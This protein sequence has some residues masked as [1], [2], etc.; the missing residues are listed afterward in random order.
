MDQK[1]W[2][3]EKPYLSYSHTIVDAAKFHFECQ[4]RNFCSGKVYLLTTFVYAQMFH[5]IVM[6]IIKDEMVWGWEEVKGFV[7]KVDISVTRGRNEKNIVCVT[8]FMYILPES[9]KAPKLE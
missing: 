1:F 7:T 5:Y 2:A 8:S 3:L 9:K 4:I 6:N